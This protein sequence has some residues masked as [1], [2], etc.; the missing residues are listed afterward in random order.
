MKNKI[1]IFVLLLIPNFFFGQS[2][3]RVK[4]GQTIKITPK[5][6]KI[7]VD[8]WIMEDNSTIII[9][10]GVDSWEINA[11]QASFGKNCRIIGRG[12]NGN[13]GNHSRK[14][15]GNGSEC[16]DGGHGG[17]GGNGQNGRVGK[18]IKITM[19][20]VFVTDL[21]ID[22]SGGNGGRGGNGGN[23]GIG[24][25]ASCGRVCSGQE[26]GNGGFG[27]NGGNGGSS[28]KV[29]VNYWI[30]G[31]TS[32]PMGE[33]SGLRVISRAGQGG[34]GGN[35]GVGGR[36]GSGK[37][38]PP[39]IKRGGGPNGKNGSNGKRGANARDRKPTFNVLPKP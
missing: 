22:T 38:C 34:I 6:K 12:T 30:A 27:G 2:L 20:L 11:S 39:F 7:L 32:I 10:E 33:N 31:S 9:G 3:L 14:H 36:G 1:S 4:T 15:G 21:I 24:G 17:T 18:S 37:S 13:N 25:R 19:G 16:V 5:Y 23:G 28:G 26:G 8:K 35:G 29:I